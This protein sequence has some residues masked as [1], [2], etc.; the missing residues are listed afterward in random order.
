MAPSDP[1]H[2]TEVLQQM[3]MAD[4]EAELGHTKT[5]LC[6]QPKTASLQGTHVQY[7]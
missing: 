2:T 7:K 5:G 4:L 1:F 3:Y 6:S